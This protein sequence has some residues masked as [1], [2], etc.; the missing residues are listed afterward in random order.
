LNRLAGQEIAR[1]GV[2]RPTSKEV[3]LFH[4]TSVKITQLPS[5]LPIDKIKVAEHQSIRKPCGFIFSC[6]SAVAN[7]S[8]EILK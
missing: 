7:C 4:H 6:A 2:V 5:R 1:T 8:A 3:T